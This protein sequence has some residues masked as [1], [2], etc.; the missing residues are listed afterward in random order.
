MKKLLLLLLIFN[1]QLSIFNSSAQ[2]NVSGFINANTTWN[3]AGSPY[4]VVGNALVSQGYTLTIDP[5]VVVKFD[6][7]KALQIDGEL[8]AI[9]TAADRITFTS[10]STNPVRGS[11]AK[12]HFSAYSTNAVFDGNGNYVSGCIMKYCDVLYGGGLGYGAIQVEGASPYISQCKVKYSNASGIHC[13]G[14][15]YLLDSSLV[16]DNTNY[17]LYFFDYS[18]SS[19]GLVINGDTIKNNRAG[20]VYLAGGSSGCNTE[21]KNCYF[22]SDSTRGGIHVFETYARVKIHNN[23][24]FNNKSNGSGIITYDDSSPISLMEIRNNHFEGNNS[25]MGVVDIGSDSNGYKI[26]QNNFISNTSQ[27][28][29]IHYEWSSILDSISCNNFINNQTRKALI[30]KHYFGPAH[31]GYI[32]G[33]YFSGNVNTQSGDVAILDIGQ[34]N[35]ALAFAYNIVDNN[36]VVNG[37]LLNIDA[38]LDNNSQALKIHHNEFKNNTASKIINI[39]G[40]QVSNSTYNFMYCQYNNFFDVSTQYSLYDSVPYGSPNIHAENNYWGSINTQHIDSIIYDYFDF[41][42]QS[43]VYYSPILTIKVALDTVCANSIP[44]FVSGIEE[45]TEDFLI[46][47]NPA[48]NSFTVSLNGLQMQNADL[49]IFDLAGRCVYKKEIQNTKYE[50]LNTNFSPGIYFVKVSDGEREEVQKLIIE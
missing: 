28:G 12:L 30:W 50:I 48:Q 41:A 42:N 43:I 39:G 15:T 14:S 47:P 17:G 4:I 29:L 5:G 22:I 13:A 25:Y 18:Q 7:M 40:N 23:Y 31:S 34:N 19:C 20:G 1:F 2:T 37:K 6:T 21:I 49:K 26:T 11:W 9:G 27:L 8:I 44:T 46:Y 45:L 33:N 3:L 32:I 35:Q 38:D 16:S 36:T 10:S 24:F